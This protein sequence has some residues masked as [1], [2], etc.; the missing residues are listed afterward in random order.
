MRVPKFNP[1]GI[2]P[3]MRKRPWLARLFCLAVLPIS[4]LIFAAAIL[5]ENRDGF[6]EIKE[7]VQAAFL[8]WSKP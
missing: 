7:L 6:S 4:P 3:W 2:K 5:W 8:P 1:K